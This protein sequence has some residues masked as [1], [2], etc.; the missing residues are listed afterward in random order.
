MPLV[1]RFVLEPAVERRRLTA[2]GGE[3]SH[4]VSDVAPLLELVARKLPRLGPGRRVLDLARPPDNG[5]IEGEYSGSEEELEARAGSASAKVK[6]QGGGVAPYVIET[7]GLA[8][9]RRAIGCRK[10][11]ADQTPRRGRKGAHRRRRREGRRCSLAGLC[12][13][14]EHL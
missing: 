2:K 7:E 12:R 14:L 11:A 4:N 10:G 1:V 13:H 8:E 5:P 9:A 6:N 3:G